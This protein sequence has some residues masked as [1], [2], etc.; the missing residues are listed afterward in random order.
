MGIDRSST[1]NSRGW[2][3]LL[4]KKEG[5]GAGRQEEFCPAVGRLCRLCPGRGAAGHATTPRGPGGDGGRDAA[6]A[7]PAPPAS[8]ISGPQAGPR[9]GGSSSHLRTWLSIPKT[10]DTL[11][12]VL[13]AWLCTAYVFSGSKWIPED[14]AGTVIAERGPGRHGSRVATQFPLTLPSIRER[15]G[16]LCLPLPLAWAGLPKSGALEAVLKSSLD[17]VPVS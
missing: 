5:D 12:P 10:T 17:A 14:D 4:K 8:A 11:R 16:S 7:P 15:A 3:F 13:L 1:P 9:F 2:Q 6:P